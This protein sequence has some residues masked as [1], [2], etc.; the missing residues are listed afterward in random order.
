[1]TNKGGIVLVSNTKERGSRQ[2]AKTKNQVIAKLI[3]KVGLRYQYQI[4]TVGTTL[5]V[6]SQTRP[7]QAFGLFNPAQI[8]MTCMFG[9]ASAQGN[10]LING[11][12][13]VINAAI[14]VML[15]IYF[16]SSGVKVA[17]ALGDGQ[18]VTQMVQQPVG[19]FFITLVLFIAQNILF[20]NVTAA[21]N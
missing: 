14:T 9:G 1:M 18:E 10:A 11:L 7:A 4:Y 19:I 3:G 15:F 16:V 17:N 2:R 21:C 6:A 20:A 5:I 8:A 13:G 12:P